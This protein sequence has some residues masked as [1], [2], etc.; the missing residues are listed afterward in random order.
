MLLMSHWPQAPPQVWVI[1]PDHRGQ[2]GTTGQTGDANSLPLGFI[3]LG[4]DLPFAEGSEDPKAEQPNGSINAHRGQQGSS[5]D[6]HA[7]LLL[8]AAGLPR[9]YTLLQHV[10]R[11]HET[12]KFWKW[13]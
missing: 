4:G 9:G 13:Y 5:R 1:T 2:A 8:S 11:D 10:T 7:P 3:E 6:R 12:H